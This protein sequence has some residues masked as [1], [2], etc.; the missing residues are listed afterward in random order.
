MAEATKVTS[1]GSAVLKKGEYGFPLG[2]L[3]HLSD[4]QQTALVEFKEI[5]A[6]SGL[7]KPAVDGKPS[8]HDDA[9]LL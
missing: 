1:K 9:T 6:E 2:H 3:G 4:A 7:Y 8:S 5:C